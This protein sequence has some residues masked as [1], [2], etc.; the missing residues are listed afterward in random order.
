MIEWKNIRDEKPKADK[1]YLV[2]RNDCLITQAYY[3]G[4]SFHVPWGDEYPGSTQP[5]WWAKLNTP[6]NAETYQPQT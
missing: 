3:S 4:N 2:F 5:K 1:M 6:V